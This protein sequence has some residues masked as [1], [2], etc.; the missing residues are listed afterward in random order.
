MDIP[1]VEVTGVPDPLPDGLVV[2]DVREPAEWRAGH[3]ARAVHLPLMDL[4]ARFTE[5]PQDR[6]LVVCRVGAR[7]AQATAYLVQQGYDAVNL[8]GGLVEWQAAGR[9]LVSETGQP[10]RVL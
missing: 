7:S 9:P 5:L 3:L 4:P 10:P 8:R 6:L 2:L 1:T